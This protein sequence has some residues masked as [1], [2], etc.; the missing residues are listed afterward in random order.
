MMKT[1]LICVLLTIG[2]ALATH[3]V[4]YDGFKVYKVVPQSSMQIE[5]LKYL[6]EHNTGFIFWSGISQ[7]GKPIHIMVPPH[8]ELVFA[9]F[10]KL[11]SLSSEIYIEN[12]QEKIDNERP[13]MRS[14]KFG[15]GDYYRL[16]D[17]SKQ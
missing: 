5:A 4:R 6:E 8:L 2:V 7:I 14:V 12:V 16:D 11:Q 10:I 1:S 17:V 15:W 3:K 13:K 9:D